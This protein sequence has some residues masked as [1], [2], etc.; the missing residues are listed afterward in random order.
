MRI[1]ITADSIEIQRE[2]RSIEG[3]LDM[4][5]A[6]LFQSARRLTE[7]TLGIA[8]DPEDRRVICD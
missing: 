1:T 6:M 8:D 4:A 7:E 2:G 3:A 5:T